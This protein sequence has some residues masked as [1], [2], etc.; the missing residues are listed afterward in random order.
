MATLEVKWRGK[1]NI[2]ME[3]REIGFDG[4]WKDGSGSCPVV[5]FGVS[6]VE[7]SGSAARESVN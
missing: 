4:R 2:K 1:D 3:F 5:G 6:S 7:P